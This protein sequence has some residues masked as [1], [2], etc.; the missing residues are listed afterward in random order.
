MTPPGSSR[1]CGTEKGQVRGEGGGT[2]AGEAEAEPAPPGM[3]PREGSWPVGWRW[4][5]LGLSIRGV[6]GEQVASRWDLGLN[7]SKQGCA[8]GHF[9]G[10]QV[11]GA[12][13]PWEEKREEKM[14]RRPS[15]LPSTSPPPSHTLLRKYLW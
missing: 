8:G 12:L 14:E 2:P 4:G 3:E 11:P 7:P 5:H 15:G 9:L 6:V 10:L 13:Q 1:L